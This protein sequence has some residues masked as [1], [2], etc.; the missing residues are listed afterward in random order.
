[1]TSKSPLPQPVFFPTPPDFR[2]WLAAHHATHSELL[3]GFY[4]KASKRPSITWPESVDEALCFGWIDG[5]RRNLDAES[6]SIRF[7]PRRVTSIWSSINIGRVDELTRNGRMMPAGIRAYEARKAARSGIYTYENP[8]V[9]L[10]VEFEKL[11]RRK[12]AAY[13]FFTTQA[14]SYQRVATRWVMSAKQEPTRQRR[15]ALLIEVSTEGRRLDAY[16]YKEK[17]ARSTRLK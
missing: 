11:F 17:P 1:V 8:P 13:A 5:V 3:V 16:S 2:A 6:Y 15:L 9:G 7:T 10:S 4:K 14:P 12:R